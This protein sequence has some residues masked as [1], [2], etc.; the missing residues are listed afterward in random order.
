MTTRST[1]V[2]VGWMVLATA[3]GGIAR[4]AE[5]ATPATA[6]DVSHHSGEVDWQ[7]VVEQGVGLVYLKATEGVDGADPMFEDHWRTLG[8]LG[9]TRGAYHFFVTEDD[10]EEQARFFLS[11]LELAPGDLPPVV[12][13]ELIGR[14]TTGDLKVSLRRVLEIVEAELGVIPVIY[15]SPNFWNA[16]FDA[17]F[18]RFPL[19]IAEYGVDQPTLPAGWT[20]W[21]MWQYEENAAVP[22]IEKGADRSRLHPDADV[23]KLTAQASP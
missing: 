17:S 9:V 20:S 21:L 1:I 11:R 13:V 23:A 19:W 7:R 15:T 14:G 22:G 16:H 2:T 18:G 12:D 6:I 8:E 4:A 5:P 3:A 10:P